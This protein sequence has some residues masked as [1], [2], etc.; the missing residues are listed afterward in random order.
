MNNQCHLS[1]YCLLTGL[2]WMKNQEESRRTSARTHTHT[3]NGK[4]IQQ[5]GR[6]Q[7]YSVRV[8][9]PTYATR[10]RRCFAA[11]AEQTMNKRS[12]WRF[13][14]RL[15]AWIHPGHHP[16][17]RWLVMRPPSGRAICSDTLA[18]TNKLVKAERAREGDKKTERE[19]DGGKNNFHVDC[20][21]GAGRRD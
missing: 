12:R 18:C 2:N 13:D 16:H 7:S 14:P 15:R 5:K 8:K 19:R 10:S 9:T 11:V 20:C 17:L 6:R 1:D 3:L 4:K 21:R